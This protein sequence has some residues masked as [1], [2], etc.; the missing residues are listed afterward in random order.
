MMMMMMIV[1][2]TIVRLCGG[3]LALRC[4]LNMMYFSPGRFGAMYAHV[5]KYLSVQIQ[6]EP[7]DPS[8]QTNKQSSFHKHINFRN[9]GIIANFV[10]K[11]IIFAV[12]FFICTNWYQ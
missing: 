10:F 2:L 5:S 3:G 6:S 1:T 9:T 12:F 7:L 11:Y 8:E 4:V